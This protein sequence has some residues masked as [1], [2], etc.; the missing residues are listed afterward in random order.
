MK[1]PSHQKAVI[2]QYGSVQKFINNIVEQLKT[3]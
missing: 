3:K 1:Y 2:A